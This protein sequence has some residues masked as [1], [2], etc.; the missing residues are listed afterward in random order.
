MVVGHGGH[1][2]AN[3]LAQ[4]GAEPVFEAHARSK[5]TSV[6]VTGAMISF[7]VHRGT[8]RANAVCASLQIIRHATAGLEWAA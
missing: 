1:G 6:K 7:D 3:D 8:E 2:I 5:T 4:A